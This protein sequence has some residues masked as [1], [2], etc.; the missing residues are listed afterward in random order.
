MLPERESSCETRR[1]RF[2]FMKE[3]GLGAAPNCGNGSNRLTP[4]SEWRSQEME[5]ALLMR[6]TT[7]GT[8]KKK[9]IAKRNF[10]RRE[11][12]GAECLA[13]ARVCE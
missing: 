6:K 8:E 11:N 5:G 7:V 12:R 3:S 4:A 2:D 9:T 10:L 13:I 1:T